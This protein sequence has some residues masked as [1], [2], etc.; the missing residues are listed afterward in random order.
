MIFRQSACGK[1][2][3][4]VALCRLPYFRGKS[5]SNEETDLY[6]RIAADASC[7]VEPDDVDGGAVHALCGGT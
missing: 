2:K 6:G 7:R 4:K 5:Q 3:N 1:M